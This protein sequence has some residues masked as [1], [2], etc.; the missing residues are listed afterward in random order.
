[1]TERRRYERK[2]SHEVV[3]YVVQKGP[4]FLASVSHLR[5]IS[6]GGISFYGSKLLLP[7]QRVMVYLEFPDR[8]Y[9]IF[10]LCRI[11]WNTSHYL[12]EPQRLI[13]AEFLN[14]GIPQSSAISDHISHLA[15]L[16]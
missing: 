5:N 4:I 14:L 1:M 16:S 6:R 11:V 12:N 9:P 3:I 10:T 7:G 2:E 8:K 13:G 15:S